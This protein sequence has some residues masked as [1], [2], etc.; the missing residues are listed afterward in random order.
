MLALITHTVDMK[1]WL[2]EDKDVR[3]ALIK[4]AVKQKAGEGWH[5]KLVVLG[6]RSKKEE[7]AEE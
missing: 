2:S 6:D 1:K 7:G 3:N 5:G 4:E